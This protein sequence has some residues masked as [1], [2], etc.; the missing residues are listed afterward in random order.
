MHTRPLVEANC[1]LSSAAIVASPTIMPS[2]ASATLSVSVLSFPPLV[3]LFLLL[4]P[5]LVPVLGRFSG[6]NASE[7]GPG[8]G[9]SRVVRPAFAYLVARKAAYQCSSNGGHEPALCVVW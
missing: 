1:T 7:N 5:R 4:V 2:F 9:C 6:A 3:S 8:H